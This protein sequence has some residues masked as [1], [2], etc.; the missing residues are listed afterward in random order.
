MR[1]TKNKTD[2]PHPELNQHSDVSGLTARR[3]FSVTK[4]AL[5]TQTLFLFYPQ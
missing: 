2:M 4:K 1:T 3:D 5:E